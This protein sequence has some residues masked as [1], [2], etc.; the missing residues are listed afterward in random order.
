MFEVGKTY[1]I[2]TWEGSEDGG[3]PTEH[4]GCEVIEV[5]FPVVKVRQHGREWII[6][7]S[8]PGITGAK[9]QD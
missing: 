3:I 4:P 7:M 1:T 6:N 2:I 9:P 8:S 5:Q